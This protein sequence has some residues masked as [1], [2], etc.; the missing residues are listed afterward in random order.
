MSPTPVA[1]GVSVGKNGLL[2]MMWCAVTSPLSFTDNKSVRCFNR[3]GWEKSG[4]LWGQQG[5]YNKLK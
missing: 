5:E 2:R 1:R 3:R 4:I